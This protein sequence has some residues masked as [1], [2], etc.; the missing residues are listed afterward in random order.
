MNPCPLSPPVTL[1]TLTW[2]IPHDQVIHSS[3]LAVWLPLP[4]EPALSLAGPGRASIL[5]LVLSEFILLIWLQDTHPL[6]LA[7]GQFVDWLSDVLRAFWPRDCLFQV[8]ISIPC[9]L[10]YDLRTFQNM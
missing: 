6:R 8:K 5:G 10:V 7:A 4:C 9:G 3:G 1:N 2:L